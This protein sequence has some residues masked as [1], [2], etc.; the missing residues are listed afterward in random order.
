VIKEV[1][2][3]LADKLTPLAA[4]LSGPWLKV[5]NKSNLRE[6]LEEEQEPEVKIEKRKLQL[7]TP[8]SKTVSVKPSPL[9]L[10]SLFPSQ[11]SK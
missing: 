3:D 1:Q 5:L 11:V 2:K 7:I 10:S 6:Q 8:A 4:D 9:D